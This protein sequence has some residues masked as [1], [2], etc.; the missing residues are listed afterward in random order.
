MTEQIL[1]G[2]LVVLLT[3][4]AQDSTPNA[5]PRASDLGLKVG[6]LPAGPLDAITDVTG[7]EVGHTIIIPGDDSRIGVTA[8][9]P[10]SGNLFREKVLGACPYPAN[11]ELHTIM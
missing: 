8:I 5:R 2:M 4:S 7:V 11:P 10:H 9:L 6:V 1:A 3:A